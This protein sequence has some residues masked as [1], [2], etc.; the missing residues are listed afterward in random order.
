M[1][2][3]FAPLT[4]ALL[5]AAAVPA[6]TQSAAAATL[7]V[8]QKYPTIQ[9]ALNAA[10]PY[11]TVLVSPKPKGGVY[12]EA[13]T[14]ATPHVVLS[15]VGNPVIDGTG[16]GTIVTPDP[17]NP[18]FT[19]TVYPN[20]ISILAD[21]VAVRGL[22]VQNVGDSSGYPSLPAGI[23]AGRQN[24]DTFVVT[25]VADLEISGV[26]VR[27]SYR[28]IEIL[29][30]SDGVGAGGASVSLKGFRLLGNVVT[31]NFRNGAEILGGTDL[32][33][34]GNQFT[35]NGS[36]G[37]DIGSDPTQTL[38][39][40]SAQ[41]AGNTFSGNTFSGLV[42]YGDGLQIA[43]NEIGSNKGR[44]LSILADTYNPAAGTPAAP[45]PPASLVAGNSIHDN[46]VA[47]VYI[48]GTVSVTGNLI[49]R[50]T[51][52]GLYFSSAEFSTATGNTI[53]GT[54]YD[55][56][57]FFAPPDA[58]TA[59]YADGNFY[60]FS[61]TAAGDGLKIVGNFLSGNAGDGIALAGVTGT[62]VSGNSISGS[63][64]IGIH[65]SDYQVFQS[66]TTPNIITGNRALGSAKFDA[67]D[68][69]SAADTITY[70]GTTYPGDGVP[71]VNVWTRNLFGTTDPVGLSK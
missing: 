33:I 47:G 2:S 12:N 46:L 68:D 61:S 40:L 6:C 3:S 9:K 29:G 52:Y 49:S 14:M 23:S 27:S 60:Q 58:G 63:G 41:I 4:I 45:N 16:L 48:N 21:H 65:A 18:D 19:Y 11:D 25:G 42:I 13:V 62:T 53:T 50:N 66:I 22:T 54:L 31:K 59:I 28:G 30:Y 10:K 71:T 70:N 64:G 57:S 51:N 55:A 43:G 69:S 1:R 7:L 34:A 56:G 5:A 8:P 15:G 44:G 26:T 32:Q 20:G 36:D 67:R 37:L 24:P 39:P 38:Y 35:G 17:A